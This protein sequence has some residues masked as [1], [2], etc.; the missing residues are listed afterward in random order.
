MADDPSTT[1]T[2]APD[3]AVTAPAA[4]T[5]TTDT[6]TTE[7][8]KTLGPAGEKALAEERKA[9]KAAEKLA[10]DREAKIREFEDRDKT[11][12]EKA[13]ASAAA[14]EKRAVE[15]EARAIRAEV[16]AEKGVPA[17]LAKFVSGATR[18][19]L[20]AAADELM[21]AIPA[22]QQKP[23]TPKPDPGQGARG[24]DSAP[25][26]EAGAARYAERHKQKTTT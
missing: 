11:D 6:G 21:A 22:A 25:T 15:L 26:V 24:K 2:A 9:R 3:G 19:E 20:E 7:G 1:A 13:Q 4:A 16:V 12:L 8:D 18:E 5:A 14:A 10:A 17:N 23:G